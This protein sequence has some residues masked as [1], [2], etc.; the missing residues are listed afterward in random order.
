MPSLFY[1]PVEVFGATVAIGGVSFVVTRTGGPPWSTVSLGLP[2]GDGAS[3]MRAIDANTFL[4]G[5][6]KGRMLRVSWNG[7][8]W[9][10]KNLTCHRRRATSAASPSTRA[11]RCASG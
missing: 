10:V 6:T 9:I 2:T 4:V 3:A 7:S 1:P 5:T 11:T 8:D